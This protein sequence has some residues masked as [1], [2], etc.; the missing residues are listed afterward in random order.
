MN[1]TELSPLKR[2]LLAIEEL[3][4]KLDAVEKKQHEPIAIIGVGCRIPGGANNP[5]E[6]WRL[7]YEGRN[8][9][10]EISSDRWD[11]DAYYDPNPDAPGKIATRF[12]GFLDQVD[13]FEPQF[14]EIAP[15]EA[16]TMD[17]QQRLLLEVSWEALE[18]AGQSPTKL[19]HTRTGVYFGVCSNDYAQLLLEAGDPALVDMYFASGIA[20]SIASGRVSYVLGLQG[21]SMS[22]DT[23]CSSSLVAIH[24]ACQSLRNKECNLALAGGANVILSPEIFSALSRA[25]MLAPDGKCKTFDLSADGFVRGEGCG[26]VVLK[27]LDHALAEGDRVLALIRGSAINQDGPSSGL[28]APNGPSQE[29]VIREALAN[30]GVDPREVSYIEAHGTG[31]SL[32]DPIEVQAMGAVFGPGREAAAPLLIGSVKTN[33]GHLEAAAGVSGLIKVV[34]SLQHREIPQHLHF[35][36]PSPHIPWDRLPV[37]VTSERE[38]W[39]SLHGKRIAGVSSF[40]FSGTNAHVVLEEAPIV[41]PKR[42][43]TERPLHLLTLSAR[44]EPALFTLIELYAQRME[45]EEQLVLPNLCHT[46]NVGRA[47]LVHRLTLT[48]T[49]TEAM[50]TKLRASRSG[51]PI[52]GVAMGC[53]EGTERPKIAFLFTGQGSQYVG[54]GRRLYETS[55]TFARALNRCDAALRDHL[56][57]SLLEVL[58]PTDGIDS[59]INETKFTQPALFA[60]EYALCE[61]WRSWGVQPTFVLGHSVGEYVAACV[62]GVFSVEDGLK[63]IAERARLMQAQPS[64]GRMA[65]VMAPLAKVR[66]ILKPLAARVS[67]AAVNG[68]RQTV[69]SGAGEDV[70][71]L[72]AQFSAA[73]FKSRE[74]TVSHAFHSPLM[75]PMLE[76]FERAAAKVSFD[77]PRLRLVSN[78]TGKVTSPGQMVQLNYW[79]RH[80]LETVQYAASMQTLADAGC[81]VF[82]E[83]GPNPVLVGLG[84]SCIDP[85]GGLWLA[86]MRSGRD[87]WD[88][89]LASL[90]QLYVHGVDVDWIGFD[91]D[92]PRHKVS[93]PTYPF[94]RERYFVDRQTKRVERPESLETLHPFAE[95]FIESPSLNDIVFETTLSTAS[96]RFLD[97]H[98][99]FGR[100]IFPATGYLEAVRAAAR[101]G[102]GE[103][104][105]AVENILI[106]EA[107]ALDDTETRRLQV[108]LSRAGDTGE[109]AA[110]F[111]VFSAEPGV[112]SSAS[113]WRL[114]ASGSLRRVADLDDPIHVDFQALK[115]GADEIGAE[116]FY[117]DY[118]R[119]GLDFGACFRGVKQVWRHPGKALGLIEPPLALGTEPVAYDVHPALLDACLQ[120]VA[121]AVQSAD[122]DQTENAIFMPLGVQ[123]FRVFAPAMGKLWSLATV[124]LPIKAHSETIEAQVQVADEQGR[125]IAEVR[126]MS[127]KRADQATLERAT[128]RSIDQWLYEITWEPLQEAAAGGST[129]LPKFE[130]LIGSLQTDLDLFTQTSGLNRFEQLRPP[131][132]AICGAYIGRALREAGL[133]PV[134][135][136]EFEIENLANELGI[137]PAH[138]QVFSRFLE[139]LA[140]DNVLKLANNRGR[141]LEPLPTLDIAAAMNELGQNFGEFEATL[142][143]T[144][145]CGERLCAALT[146]RTDPLHLLFPAGDL[147]TAE[148]LYQY[149]PSARTFNPLVRE[150]IQAAVHAWP[151]N[152]PLRILEVGAGTGATTAHVLP[153]LPFGRASYLFTDLSPLF[154]SRA[155]A[156]FADF[157]N[158]T[159]QLLDLEGDLSTQGL[160]PNSFDIIIASNVIHATAEVKQTLAGMRRLLAP[161]GWLL[162]LEV[163]RPQRWFDVTFGL[164]AGW[165][166]FH[167]HDLRTRYP[168][169]SRAEWKRLLLQSDFN[170]VLTVPGTGIEKE[171][172]EDQAMIIARVADDHTAAT[173]KRPS[174]PGKRWLILADRRGT[175]RQLA[176]RLAAQGDNCALVFARVG[177][178]EPADETTISDPRSPDD[179]ERLIRRHTSGSESPFHGIV[180]LWPLDAEPFAQLDETGVG[181]EI[182]SWCGGALHLVQALARHAWREPP[183]L[184]LC[185]RGAQK[186]DNEDK[187][188][189]PVAATVWGLGKVIAL[190][191]PELRCVR[192]D[193]DPKSDAN[194]IEF[195]SAALEAEDNED[196]VALRGDRRLGARLQRVKRP[197]ENADPIAH[198]SGKPYHLTFA[199]RGS[200]ENLKLDI[201]HRRPP[202]PGEVEIRVLATA[203]N[204]RDVMNVMGLYPG[205]PGPMGAECA[206]EIVAVGE[207]IGHF[208]I[209]DPVVAIAPGSFAGYVTTKADWVA[210][211]PVRMSFDEAVTIPIAF[212]TAQFT[213]NH[214]AKIK[215]GDR[216][217]IHAA[218]GGVGLAAVTLAKRAGAEIF[219][220]AGSP[221]KRAFLKSLGVPHVMD[222]R[223]L[224]FADEIMQITGGRGVDVVLNSLADRFVDRSFQVIGQGGRFLEIGKRG[225]WSPERAA[226]LNRGI[227]YF[228][229]D[230]SVDAKNHPALI[231]TIFHELIASFERGEMES[232]PHRVFPLR[233]AKTAFRYMAQGRHTGKVV[234]SHGEMLRLDQAGS[235]FDSQGTYLISGGLHGLGLMTAQWLAERGARHLVLTGRRAPDPEAAA[236]LMTMESQGICVRVAQ[237]DVSDAGAMKHLL[238]ETRKTMPPLRG[239]FHSAGVLD[240]GILIQQSWGRFEKVF[241]SKVTGSL[242]LHRLTMPD[243]L[244]FFVLYSS[245]AAIF[246]SPGQGNHVAANAFMD[247]LAAAR[248][249]A[250]LRGLSINWGAWEGAGAAVDHDV[251]ERAREAGYGVIDP[252]GGFMALE[253]ALNYRQSQVIVLPA[254]WPR[255]LRHFSRGGNFRLFLSNLTGSAL[256]ARSATGERV[257]GRDSIE[258][259]IPSAGTSETAPS[260]GDRLAAAPP[261]QR[262]ALVIEQI[263]N[264]TARV[265]GLE[266]LDLLPSNKPLN[267]LGLD[268]LMAVELCNSLGNAMGHSLPATLLYDYPTVEVLAR[269]LSHS[270]LGLEEAPAGP[271]RSS[272][273]SDGS[274]MLDQIENLDEA[275]IDRLL[276]EIGT[277]TP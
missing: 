233:E 73:G 186:A 75:N 213:L 171:E 192:I 143:M 32:G 189:S 121:G 182:Q 61:L 128:R 211:K 102:L 153:V 1:T 70:K 164:T 268:S 273:V 203:L 269:Y 118:R 125:L 19:S 119:R 265:L 6:F 12:G 58:Y 237:A 7:L 248:T 206:G 222:S 159:F 147:T 224:A 30:A 257:D 25:R 85:E 197:A 256:G 188:L 168:L 113:S 127:F 180:Y 35:Q 157:E 63:L 55:P 202:G 158:V 155:K 200:L 198:L 110:R 92:Y 134:V 103:A 56:D 15:R 4:A 27:R 258:R 193:L 97:D 132:N 91:R 24:L 150:A 172:A 46:A 169:L 144:A 99:V 86:S 68:P 271:V 47:H 227:Q 244:D 88:E 29:S 170:D 90:G 255:F 74:L 109:V 42:S 39:Q 33:V 72:L 79:R 195:L 217:L 141:W 120:V 100:I 264:D 142:A 124:D 45:A 11:V 241:A 62:A 274:D 81:T 116:L 161:G 76:P 275:E 107:L 230:W 276:K 5:E 204:F 117:A 104:N 52:P 152:R 146:G 126:G 54:M 83:I 105:W 20:H 151:H 26:V 231:D 260:F 214:L 185:T 138:R 183:K 17:P 210:P 251:T 259:A 78:L 13:R 139:I 163:T 160:H 34:L 201:A 140:E 64:G 215:A 209:G 166:R 216:V 253:T 115:D 190:E 122:E 165:W 94:Q 36:Q 246:G 249:E 123:S 95:R 38:P 239:V 236:A 41:Q 28:T 3:Q 176:K 154:L 93:L 22:V 235:K 108:V 156:K 263:R 40:G 49:D 66:E 69:I 148:K 234:I 162:M 43:A 77:A 53:C 14:F 16:L 21:P 89:M 199:S 191:H 254:D 137:T 225:I 67:I 106:G 194:E 60:L 96:H 207:G 149:S 219:A 243:T 196:Q 167:D 37:R 135:G 187:G 48:G 240:D 178:S 272:S 112:A 228:I 208:A 133:N 205:D 174:S 175:G 247:T 101:L 262:R 232:L 267:E 277:E 270:V 145:R 50:I 173:A 179:M 31:T 80:I 98:R 223:S 252:R 84:R 44:T 177:I 130:G 184:W 212:I 82:L 266:N 245:V 111:Q 242:L 65:A 229:V 220:T 136:G 57:R 221:E 23:A 9:V 129:P 18:N 218:A 10:R 87:D 51:K 8:G 238:E 261:N 71:D 59:P 226:S 250:G 181:A 114:H 131:L 2:A